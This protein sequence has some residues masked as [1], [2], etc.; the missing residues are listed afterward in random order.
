MNV[1]P[2]FRRQPRYPRNELH[3]KVVIRERL[4]EI[5]LLIPA[6][7]TM[8]LTYFGISVTMLETGATVVQKGQALTFAIAIGVFAWLGWFFLFG[9]IYR[10]T[11]ARLAATLIAGTIS[12]GT[13]A[14][15]DA[16]FN[17]LA[18]AGGSAVQM[19]LSDTTAVYEEKKEAAYARATTA[20][21]LIPAIRAQAERFTGLGDNEIAYGTHSGKRGPGKVSSGFYQIASLLDSLARQL[22][23]SIAE[24]RA[25]Q[26]EI[27]REF[28]VMKE[29]TLRQGQ[30]RPRVEAATIAADRL[31]DL[32]ARLRQQ[33]YAASLR[34]TIDSLDTIFPAPTNASSDFEVVQNRELAVIAE[35][36]TPVAAA[37]HAGLEELETAPVA[38]P[39]RKRPENAHTAIRTY[40][41]PLLAEWCAA[42][43]IDIA[44]AM[45]LIILTAAWREHGRSA[46]A[47]QPETADA[48]GEEAVE[49]PQDE[50][51]SAN[52]TGLV[53][54]GILTAVVTT[55]ISSLV[56]YDFLGDD[57]MRAL[58]SSLTTRRPTQTSSVTGSGFAP[59]KSITFFEHMP[60]G[61]TVLEVT[62]GAAYKSVAAIEQGS[63]ESTWCYVNL[64]IAGSRVS[65]HVS[66]GSQAGTGPPVLATSDT[67]RVVDASAYDLDA[68]GLAALAKTHCRFGQ[69]DPLSS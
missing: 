45:L 31:D 4:T 62:T 55:G 52:R 53:S 21:R 1:L 5:L 18:I 28:A 30:I 10:L 17:M 24:S 60:I 27:G 40:W 59:R 8:M 29:V 49:R 44:P 42:V 20:Q 67:L 64:P 69:L 14:A 46:K 19:S 66:L 3:R 26:E 37:L 13:L 65:N 35:M 48:F 11:G 41:E 16:P 2:F 25:L 68:D 23:A 50:P 32:L 9:L 15:I 58:W 34:A 7:G 6:F 61:G 51:P 22:E 39:A 54:A 43:F 57:G 36:A 38:E 12:V 56:A 63:P 33:D 47:S